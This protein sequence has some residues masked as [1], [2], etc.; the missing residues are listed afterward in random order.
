MIPH[1]RSPVPP[2]GIRYRQEMRG[3]RRAHPPD[4][5]PGAGSP[6]VMGAADI[7]MIAGTVLLVQS[8]IPE[9]CRIQVRRPY[10]S[11]GC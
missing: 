8:R 1:T 5:S 7:R 11:P 3:V 9:K 2:H 4:P 6:A 10:L